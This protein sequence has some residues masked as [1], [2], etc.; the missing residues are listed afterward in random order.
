[1]QTK[2]TQPGHQQLRKGRVSIPFQIYF[3]TVVCKNRVTHF[4]EFPVAAATSRKIADTNTWV[5]AKVMVG[6]GAA[7][8]F[9]SGRKKQAPAWMQRSGLEWLF[10]LVQEPRRLGRRYVVY[11]SQFLYLL[12]RK[13]LRRG[14]A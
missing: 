8:D 3:I 9:H 12:A 5:D 13:A 1:M 10:R 4:A 11:N 6:V 2:F 14:G 7:F